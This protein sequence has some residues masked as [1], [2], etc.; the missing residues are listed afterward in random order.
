MVKQKLCFVEL[1]RVE[2]E[3]GRNLLHLEIQSV[4]NGIA[5]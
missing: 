1:T 5:T 3:I 4:T 2:N